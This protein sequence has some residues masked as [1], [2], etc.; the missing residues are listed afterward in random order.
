M[1]TEHTEGSGAGALRRADAM[2][3]WC[4]ALLVVLF[5]AV[6]G[7]VGQVQLSPSTE[8]REHL[9]TRV[10]ERAQPAQRGDIVDRRG[11]VL[12]TTRLG[13][14]LFVDPSA[15]LE[16]YG[17]TID[18]L[19]R[20]TGEPFDSVAQR[21]VS[22]AS[23][24]E[25]RVAS[26]RT[27]IRYAS[28]GGVLSDEQLEEA[29]RLD[30]PGV[31][32]ER[33]PVRESIGGD[34]IASLVGKVGVEHEGLLGAELA[35]NEDLPGEPGEIEATRDARGNPLWM[36][37]AGFL[38]AKQGETVRLSV[39]QEIQRLAAEE[40]RRGV[41]EADAAGG[42][43]V[44][45]DPE[46]GDVLAM[47]DYVREMSGLA[48]P[49]KREVLRGRVVEPDSTGVRYRTIRPDA[50]RS[51]HPA[52]AR[53]RCVEDIY[54][55]G[56]TFK[57]FIWSSVTERG[58]ARSDEYFNTH[59]GVWVTDYGRVI[60]DVVDKPQMTWA[61]VL[62]NS[63]NIGMVQ[64]ASRLSF[65]QTRRDVLRFGFGKKTGLG[66]AGEADGLVTS[67]ARWSK[68]TQTSIASGYEIGVTPAQMVRAFSVFARNGELAGTLPNLRLRVEEGADASSQVR[69]Q[70]VPPWLAYL[71]RDTLVN[72]G[73]GME[74]RA[75]L[76][77]KDEPVL[78]HAIFGKSGTA[79]IPRPDGKG[80]FRGQY[81][82][83]FIA[84]APADNPRIVLVVVIDDPGPEMIRQRM[85][86]GTAVAGPVVRRVVRRTLEYMGV[87][88]A[89]DA[90]TNLMAEAAAASD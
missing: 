15:L 9:S 10:T 42:R 59:D 4:G 14:R 66:L 78:R 87:P 28:I 1:S 86:Y 11:R 74:Q 69:Y 64:G 81:N 90:L 2:A 52:M 82:S 16:P 5:V 63:S 84:G 41:H 50:G 71:T 29:R 18:A 70:V 38:H 58:L 34:D 26:G 77:F 68:Y 40:L 27:P 20:V 88:A 8:L 44:M 53:N 62:I 22:K 32:L 73:K 7:R 75:R 89:G 67:P 49:P 35:F 48:D 61:E 56:S 80:Y 39:D 43:L 12:A 17:S 72:V 57:C 79:E 23:E 76:R 36:R 25:Q 6:L 60:R 46:S 54:E 83:S 19:A 24:S 47:V 33:V 31:H 51:S 3:W 30:L 85:H 21:V 13:Y 65:D 55:P 37:P 45:V